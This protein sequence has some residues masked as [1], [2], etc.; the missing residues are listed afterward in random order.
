MFG[1]NETTKRERAPI[2]LK[3]SFAEREQLAAAM[4]Q[5]LSNPKYQPIVASR[6]SLVN[7]NKLL[8]SEGTS[9]V[10]QS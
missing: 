5:S 8:A 4:V 3:Q 2:I 1:L 9:P 10:R 6:N 7:A